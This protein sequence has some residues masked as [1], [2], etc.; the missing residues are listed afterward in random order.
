MKKKQV[1][2]F[3]QQLYLYQVT[4]TQT[5]VPTRCELSLGLSRK[6]AWDKTGK[7]HVSLRTQAGEVWVCGLFEPNTC[8]PIQQ[9]K[10]TKT[11]K[12]NNTF[13]ESGHFRRR[14]CQFWD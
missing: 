8:K 5:L 7:Q 11:T 10:T 2:T 4:D 9:Q 3:T 13:S 14:K 6:P 12:E 1:Q